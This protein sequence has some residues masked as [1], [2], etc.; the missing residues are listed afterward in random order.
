M[1]FLHW[2]NNSILTC[3]Y[4]YTYKFSLILKGLSWCKLAPLHTLLR[5][6][7]CELNAPFHLISPIIFI[8]IFMCI[9]QW[10]NCLVFRVE[11]LV[12]NLYRPCYTI[13]RFVLICHIIEGLHV[14]IILGMCWASIPSM[15]FGGAS[16]VS[17]LACNQLGS[18]IS[19][20]LTI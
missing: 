7:S 1:Y 19:S 3:M 17:L 14:Y 12:L 5:S 20:V 8:M 6:R 9:P 10:L 18:K 11:I 13:K 2:A 15:I 4:V 16:M